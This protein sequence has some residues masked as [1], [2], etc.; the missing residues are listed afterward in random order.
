MATYS[1]LS[2]QAV[3]AANGQG[4]Y[5][6]TGSAGGSGT[7]V[8][9]AKLVCAINYLL[10]LPSFTVKSPQ[11][12][13]KLYLN[14]VSTPYTVSAG[15]VI[16]QMANAIGLQRFEINVPPVSG[17]VFEGSFKPI[18]LLGTNV[19]SWLDVQGMGITSTLSVNI[20]EINV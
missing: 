7:V 13:G 12:V 10:T 20:T 14:V 19:W 3:Q 6:N 11:S 18:L 9:V 5:L 2:S 15:S 1:L 4:L 8:T 16:T 17:G